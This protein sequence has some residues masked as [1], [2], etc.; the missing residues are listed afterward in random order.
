[1]VGHKRAQFNMF[2]RPITGVEVTQNIRTALV[3][4]V[5]VDEGILL[6][7]DM[8]NLLKETLINRLVLVDVLHW[9]LFGGGLAIFVVFL[10]WYLCT[11]NSGGT[12]I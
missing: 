6:N 3:P 5:W 1:M 2:I 9:V 10:I 8:V 4:I 11:R 12:N 7:E